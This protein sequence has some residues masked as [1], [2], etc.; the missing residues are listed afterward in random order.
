MEF[1]W[2]CKD[3]DEYDFFVSNVTSEPVLAFPDSNS[4]VPNLNVIDVFQTH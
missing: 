3:V 2:F 4:P 1:A